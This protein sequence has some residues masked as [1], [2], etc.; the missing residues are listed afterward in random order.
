MIVD[1]D[2]AH[3]H[4]AVSSYPAERYSDI[5]SMIQSGTPPLEKREAIL[6]DVSLKRILYWNAWESSG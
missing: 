4:V 3:D 1:N 5:P 6:P 2:V